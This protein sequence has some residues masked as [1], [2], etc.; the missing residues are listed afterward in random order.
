MTS[1][2]RFT[3]RNCLATYWSTC[4]VSN[5]FHAAPLLSLQKELHTH[6]NFHSSI[7]RYP[8]ASYVSP[9][10]PM[11]VEASGSKPLA[12][13]TTNFWKTLHTDSLR[14]GLE[15]ETGG[16]E[17]VWGFGSHSLV[18]G[19][20]PLLFWWIAAASPAADSCWS[21]EDRWNGGVSGGSNGMKPVPVVWCNFSSEA[22]K[23]L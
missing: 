20:P 15:E 11:E 9:E 1:E 17:A 14:A 2:V 6:H 12:N 23:S 16:K 5:L 18:A 19:F 3:E 22:A 10:G 4:S 8:D 13:G 21:S 7:L